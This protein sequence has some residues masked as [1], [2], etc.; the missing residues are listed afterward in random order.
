LEQID[1]GQCKQE[2]SSKLVDG[3]D[4]IGGVEFPPLVARKESMSCRCG[5]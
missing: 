2:F 1:Q 4:Q 5:Q 3:V